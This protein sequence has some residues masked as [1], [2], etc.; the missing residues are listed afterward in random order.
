VIGMT[1]ARA[2]QQLSDAGLEP[3]YGDKA[4]SETVPAGRVVST[5][6]AAGSKVL[7]GGT[8]TITISL[9]KERYDV[10]RL[11]G[12]SAGDA[13]DALSA[14]HLA[15][16]TT[17]ARWSDT[18]PEGVVI[19]TSPGPG[20][21]VRRDAAVDLVV[22]KGPRPVRLRDWV[23]KDAD[24]AL[25]WLSGKGLDGKVADE[26]Y[27]DDVPK[28]DVISMTPSGGTVLHRGDDVSLVVSRGPELVEVPSVRGEGVE[29]ATRELE[30]LGFEVE[31]RDA[32]GSLG[33][34]F[35]WSQDPG[36]GDRVPKG[37]TITLSL[38]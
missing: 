21:T 16:G 23:G 24:R 13:A 9:G 31:T 6:P 22:S 8:V 17:T 33:L 11:R 19:S 32:A 36:G 26:Q 25:A 12:R 7:H 28:G 27:S 14:T 10:P 34:G 38:I 5:D 2:A 1:R 30:A 3:A 35:V 29:A 18:V 37:S 15:V 4:Y 20:T